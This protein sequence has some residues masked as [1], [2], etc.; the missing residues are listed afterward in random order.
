MP[1]L[2]VQPLDRGRAAVFAADTTRKWQQGPRALG[3]D[4]PFLRFWGQMVRWL[5]G[6]AETLQTQAGIDAS[7][8]KTI[9][10]P[11]ETIHLAA[12][13]RNRDGQGADNAKVEAAVKGPLWKRR[14]RDTLRGSRAKRALQR[15]FRA[16]NCR[17]VRYGRRRPARRIG[18]KLGT[19]VGRGRPAESRIRAARPR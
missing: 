7:A 18:L 4:S 3:Q 6:R 11:G 10:Q 9:Y 14:S 8:D 19:S 1:V 12:I 17:P 15:G 5:A 16:A 13:V 2:A